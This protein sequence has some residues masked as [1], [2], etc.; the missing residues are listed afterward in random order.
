MPFLTI[1]RRHSSLLKGIFALT[2]NEENQPCKFSYMREF[3]FTISRFS[4]AEE[5]VNNNYEKADLIASCTLGSCSNI[6]RAI[7]SRAGN[8]L[9]N[10]YL[11]TLYIESSGD[12]RQTHRNAELTPERL[13]LRIDSKPG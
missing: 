9:L 8:T 3:T 7:S 4:R 2:N 5:R 1:P 6:S 10:K 11:N 12:Y 13:D